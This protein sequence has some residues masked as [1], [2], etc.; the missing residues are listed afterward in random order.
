MSSA[1]ETNQDTKSSPAKDE[2]TKLLWWPMANLCV[3]SGPELGLPLLLCWSVLVGFLSIPIF[4]FCKHDW[5]RPLATYVAALLC[6]VALL[7]V[8]EVL[9][10]P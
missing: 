1:N 4:E 7:S 6:K 2:V 10:T 3:T 5:F 8:A 9:K